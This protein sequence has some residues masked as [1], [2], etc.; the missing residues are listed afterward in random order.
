MSPKYLSNS[1]IQILF[2]GIYSYITLHLYLRLA[3]LFYLRTLT[4][5]DKKKKKKRSLTRWL[6]LI[7]RLFEG[8]VIPHHGN[9][10][11]S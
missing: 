7:I 4:L 9:Y 2:T 8:K 11:R 5:F 10:L 3:Q 6:I 1:I